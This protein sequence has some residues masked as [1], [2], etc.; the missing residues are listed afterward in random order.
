[1]KQLV[2]AIGLLTLSVTAATQAHADFA[3]VRFSSGFCR[4][5]T[6]PAAPPQDFQYLAFRRGS[7]DHPWWQHLFATPAG[8]EIALHQAMATHRCH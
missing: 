4:V 7:P 3:V 6:P 2:F 8:A 1:M 5:W